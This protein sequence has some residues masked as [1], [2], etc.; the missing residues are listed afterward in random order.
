MFKNLSS[1]LRWVSLVVLSAVFLTS[2][3]RLLTPG[4]NTEIAELRSGQYTV[5]KDHAALL[6]KVNHLGFSTFSGRFADFDAS[7]DFNP[8]N[9]ETSCLEV[10]VN[11]SSLDVNLPEFEEELLGS[12][13][14][15][16]QAFP[17]AVFRT[18]SFVE[19]NEN[20]FT[21]L[22]ELTMHGVTAPVT[23]NVNFHGGG[24]NVLTRS[25]TLGFSANAKFLRSDF[26]VDRFTN[27]GVGDEVE[28][29]IHTE[30]KEGEAAP[31]VAQ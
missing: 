27:F 14:F 2:C 31:A 20:S 5:D 30:F 15:D 29:E 16:A 10:V 25:Y 8:V 22:G 13:W 1:K 24:R 12:S 21:F 6:F 18:T 9:I 28:L 17:Q 3:D 19:R 23:L 26:G 4:F 11:M 7:L